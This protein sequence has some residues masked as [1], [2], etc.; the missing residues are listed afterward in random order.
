MFEHI[1]FD[2]RIERKISQKRLRWPSAGR[3][4]DGSGFGGNREYYDLRGLLW[5]DVND[6]LREELELIERIEQAE[7]PDEERELIEEEFT[8]DPGGMMGLDIGVASTVAALSAAGCIPFAS[9]NGGAFG[10]LHH[11]SYPLVAFCAR[12]EHVPL[13]LEVAEQAGVGIES[14]EAGEIIV[15]AH[16]IRRMPVFAAAL[17]ERQ[18]LFDALSLVDSD[19]AT[20]DHVSGP[21]RRT[22]LF[23]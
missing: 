16:D 15:Y 13:L 2:I 21:Q 23:D 11:E 4:R 20:A 22:D 7:D 5:S 1:H 18:H 19:G 14:D 9:C 12:R 8:E 3:A 6:A 17:L 10:S